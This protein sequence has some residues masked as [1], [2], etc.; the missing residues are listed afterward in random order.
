MKQYT[1]LTILVMMLTANIAQA[2][3]D[4]I[5]YD[6][7]RDTRKATPSRST[8]QKEYRDDSNE[9]N[10]AN[11]EQYYEGGDNYYEY[12]DDY[13]DYQYSS[14]I[15][16][17]HRPVRGFGYYDH[18]YVDYYY[19]DPFYYD[20]F[21]MQPNIIVGFGNSYWNRYNRFNRWNNWNW[22]DRYWGNY[23][24]NYDSYWRPFNSFGWNSWA[25]DPWCFNGGYWGNTAYNYYYPRYSYPYYNSGNFFGGNNFS[26]NNN[27]NNGVGLN[28]G[29]PKGTHY[30]ARRGSTL[31]S[32]VSPTGISNGNGRSGYPTRD[33]S[34]GVQQPNSPNKNNRSGNAAADEVRR[35][36]NE[37]VIDN[38]RP[39]TETPKAPRERQKYTTES[40]EER[41]L[42]QRPSRER[43][44]DTEGETI[45]RPQ[46]E[47]PQRS[48]EERSRP[49][50][51]DDSRPSRT[52]DTRPERPTRTYDTPRRSSESE[53]PSRTYE[54]RP[55]RS[56]TPRQSEQRS[57]PRYDTPRQ[58]SPRYEAPR[59]QES[60]SYSPPAQQSAP[61][62]S[63]DSGGSSSGSS[64]GGSRGNSRSGSRNE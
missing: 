11:D 13:D 16:R 34:G 58:E 40:S 32:P 61:A 50:I 43:P 1:L 59:Q 14:R 30:G 44:S 20:R 7:S 57:A 26:N 41:S 53:T 6:P 62:R 18:A 51:N 33:G 36:P 22:Y 56:E 25:N 27:N 23:C 46:R 55:S 52:Y 49:S 48:S 38:S 39:S 12:D 5:Y 29:N 31:N 24:F 54:Q 9:Y 60:R 63:N 8:S 21:F 64:S 45:S 28:T 15:R 37:R 2:Q 4:D 47:L 42:Y 35:T 19:Y 17:F 3:Y 10:T